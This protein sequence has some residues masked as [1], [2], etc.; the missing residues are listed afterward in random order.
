MKLTISLISLFL[1][2]PAVVQAEQHAVISGENVIVKEGSKIL[3]EKSFDISKDSPIIAPGDYTYSG[4]KTLFKAFSFN[5]CLI[6]SDWNWASEP[7]T[8]RA[9]SVNSYSFNN[10]L[11]S[12]LNTTN[13]LELTGDFIK[14]QDE[15]W[16]IILAE[17]EGVIVGYTHINENCEASVHS[18]K[19]QIDRNY[20]LISPSN[21]IET[22]IYLVGRVSNQ[23][24]RITISKDNSH[25]VVQT[26]TLNKGQQNDLQ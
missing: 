14:S 8:G 17:T 23:Q 18:F 2:L 21:K 19:H 7:H 20:D 25:N 13:S 10:T 9:T 26:N 12:S 15:T 24:Y 4:Y 6:I 22:G 5:N 1:L 11:V 16:S 3:F